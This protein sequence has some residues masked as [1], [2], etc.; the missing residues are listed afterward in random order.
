MKRRDFLKFTGAALLA[1]QLPNVSAAKAAAPKE[2]WNLSDELALLSEAKMS[3]LGVPETFLTSKGY[4]KPGCYIAPMKQGTVTRRVVF[5]QEGVIP[6]IEEELFG[7]S[8][9]VPLPPVGTV[10]SS[11]CG[12]FLFIVSKSEPVERLIPYVTGSWDE[13]HHGKKLHTH[14]SGVVMEVESIV[15]GDDS[16]YHDCNIRKAVTPGLGYDHICEVHPHWLCSES[17]NPEVYYYTHD[18]VYP[19]ETQPESW[20]QYHR[21]A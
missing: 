3:A 19:P 1:T 13:Y 17:S 8:N 20:K 15:A 5:V 16:E 14:C 21:T 10:V 9:R 6:R 12:Q 7:E 4:V 2:Y 11:S 18:A